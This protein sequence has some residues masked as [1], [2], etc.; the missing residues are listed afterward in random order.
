MGRPY[1]GRTPQ[2]RQF[3][4][5]SLFDRA[6][7]FGIAF[8]LGGFFVYPLFGFTMAC[9]TTALGMLILAYIRG[10]SLHK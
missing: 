7:I 10:R 3:P 4:I 6:I 8:V 9:K 5:A 1:R 2:G